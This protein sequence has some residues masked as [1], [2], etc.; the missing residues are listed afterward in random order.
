[1]KILLRVF[2]LLT[3]VFALKSYSGY[4]VLQTEKLDFSAVR[5]MTSLLQLPDLDFWQEPRVGGKAVIM[6]ESRH[7]APFEFTLRSL[8]LRYSV[9]IP[10]VDHELHK[11]RSD[12]EAARDGSAKLRGTSSPDFLHFL[13]YDEIQTYLKKVAA[14]YPQ[15]ATLIDIGKSYEGR[16]M[17]VLK[18]S[19]GP[20]KCA[21]FFDGAIHAREWI[22]PPTI[23]YAINQ[24]TEHAETNQAFLDKNDFYF[25]P[26][27]NPDGYTY[28]WTVSWGCGGT[29]RACSE[30]YPG[31]APFSEPETKAMSDFVSAHPDIT[32]ALSVHSYGQER[33]GKAALS[34][35]A[36]VNGTDYKMGST[37]NVLYLAYGSTTDWTYVKQRITL[38][39]TIELPGGGVFGFTIPSSRILPV[40]IET[41]EAYKVFFQNIPASR[42]AALSIKMWPNVLSRP[43]I[44]TMRILLCV[45][46]FLGTALAHKSYEGYQVLQT[47]D[48][49]D[50]S[51]VR[52][53]ASL[54]MM[55]ELD[56][57]Q[58]PRVGG[59]ATIMVPKHL[60]APVK[61][62]LATLGLNPTVL[63]PNVETLV[64]YSVPQQLLVYID[65]G[66]QKTM[67][68]LKSELKLR[69]SVKRKT[70]QA[71]MDQVVAAYP[72]IASIISIGSSY[73][74]RPMRVLKLAN[75][76]S[77]KP[78]I[79]F[80]SAIHAREWMGPP[81]VMY[82]I[83][84]LTDNLGAN[85]AILDK[86]DF[87]FLLVS[88]PDGYIFTWSD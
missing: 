73:E 88:N 28:S 34:A 10:D 17:R 57:W 31:T 43:C 9:L 82:V 3:P 24:L 48:L 70:I 4:Q 76:P 50:V 20:G 14:D 30:T 19:S 55:E 78:A 7:V 12:I 83:N 11:E 37:A 6:L 18:L 29:N 60:V 53:L 8:G 33:V 54:H 15:I 27:T 61:F 13:T 85:Q 47:E 39:Y 63:I 77:A 1:M 51:S 62:T 69:L 80:D 64:F 38:A 84:E 58:T 21:I 71:W 59:R 16:P 25:L 74:G 42:A 5:K 66:A 72:S 52:K 23:L 22:G 36:A 35:L 75:G 81:T 86:N 68:L 2:I 45:L 40:C 87:Y 46:A 65:V 79:F 44:S 56:F 49:P 32:F 26:V 67:F 41:W